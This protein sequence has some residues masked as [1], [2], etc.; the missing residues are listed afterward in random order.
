MRTIED[1]R[2]KGIWPIDF[3]L[4]YTHNSFAFGLR[5]C[6]VLHSIFLYFFNTN[7]N[8]YKE[9]RFTF[10]KDIKPTF[11]QFFVNR[12]LVKQIMKYQQFSIPLPYRGT[13][14]QKQVLFAHSAF[15]CEHLF[16]GNTAISSDDSSQS[17]KEFL[18]E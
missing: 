12:E 8:C 3:H 14:L 6:L 13:W 15:F 7:I 10:E 4:K 2:L 1:T 11:G 9:I 18:S 5:G 16:S 17:S